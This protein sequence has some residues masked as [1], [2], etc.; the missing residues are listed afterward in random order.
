LEHPH[1]ERGKFEGRKSLMTG[2]HLS[3][4]I[5]NSAPDILSV[6]IALA[7][8][9]SGARTEIAKADVDQVAVTIRDFM[10]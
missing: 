1:F 4:A 8:I 2:G 7:P 6:T 5:A 10:S 9:I 3:R